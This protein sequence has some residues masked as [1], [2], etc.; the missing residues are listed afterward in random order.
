M[1]APRPAPAES[2]VA[3]PPG[4]LAE[5]W[6]LLHE[7]GDALAQ[8]AQLA[9]DPSPVAP[10]DFAIR[11]M[12]AGPARLMVAEWM[13][14]DCAASLHSGLTALI[15]AEEAGRDTAA[16]AM[17]LWREFDRARSGLLALTQPLH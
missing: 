7:A 3:P 8:R 1:V 11:T 2:H 12:A 16:V 15:A 4:G 9:P 14:D 10:R 6:A 17:T 13:I 5:A